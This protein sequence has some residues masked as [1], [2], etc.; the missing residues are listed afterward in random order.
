MTPNTMRA[1]VGR[2][3]AAAAR[4]CIRKRLQHV[5]TARDQSA[6]DAEAQTAKPVD[7]FDALAPALC[8]HVRLMGSV[9]VM[10]ALLGAGATLDEPAAQTMIRHL[11]TDADELDTTLNAAWDTL[12]KECAK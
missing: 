10:V 11:K 4:T 7:A 5:V 6:L 9:A 12:V 2:S 8:A 1:A 3:P